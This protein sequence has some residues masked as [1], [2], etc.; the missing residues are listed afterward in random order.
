M[1]LTRQ[2]KTQ[3][4]EVQITLHDDLTQANQIATGIPYFD[5]C[6]DLF[7]FHA[8]LRLNIQASGDIDVD[9]HHTV[10]DVGIVLG[11][12]FLEAFSEKQGRARYGLAIIPMDE[13]LARVVIDLS[14]RPRLSFN[15]QFSR[16]MIGDLATENVEEFFL[17]FTSD[18]RV[19]CHVDLI[20]GTNAHHQVEAIFKALGRSFKE[21][22]KMVG[23]A[24]PSTKGQL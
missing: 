4:T 22:I 23:D 17:A 7:A 8:G 20:R 9:D 19:T 2:R 10:E 3:E 5:H 1:K 6:L 11:E 21:A 12:L 14:N 24:L 13:A 18:A 16:E 15:A